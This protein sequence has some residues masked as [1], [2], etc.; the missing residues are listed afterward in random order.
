[1]RRIAAEIGSTKDTVRNVVNKAIEKGFIEKVKPIRTRPAPS[2]VTQLR[3]SQ[4]C[5]FYRKGFTLV[6]I[7]G[8]VG[9]SNASVQE[10]VN[11]AVANGD[12][13][14]SKDP[15]RR[16]AVKRH[17]DAIG[18]TRAYKKTNREVKSTLG[19][20]ETVMC[21]ASV[22]AKCVYGVETHSSDS[23]KCRYSLCTGK[24]RS[25]GPDGCSWKACTKFSKVSATNPRIIVGE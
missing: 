14:S 13:L 21:T 17:Q 2:A 20:N 23:A 1:M 24:C 8:E 4:I 7:A 19:E 25:V 16:Q 6:E 9:I 5:D 15:R 22:S 10:Y 3:Y 18:A 11:K 12:I